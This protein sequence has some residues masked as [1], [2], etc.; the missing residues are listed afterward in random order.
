MQ[1]GDAAYA[2]IDQELDLLIVRIDAAGNVILN[3]L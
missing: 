2:H 3:E 1:L